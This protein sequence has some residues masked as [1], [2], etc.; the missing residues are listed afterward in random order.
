MKQLNISSKLGVKRQTRV[1]FSL[2]NYTLNQHSA[3]Q[4]CGIESAVCLPCEQRFLSGMAF[5]IY[6]V[7]RVVCESCRK[8]PLR[9]GYCQWFFSYNVL[10]QQISLN[11]SRCFF[12]QFGYFDLKSDVARLLLFKTFTDLL[13]WLIKIA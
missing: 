1:V 10:M 7:I 2:H 6:E 13:V 3:Y 8:K 5:S 9:A 12:L 11:T 4:P